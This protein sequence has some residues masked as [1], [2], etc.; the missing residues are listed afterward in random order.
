MPISCCVV[1]HPRTTPRCSPLPSLLSPTC[2]CDP[3]QSVSRLFALS[4]DTPCTGRWCREGAQRPNPPP[5]FGVA[6]TQQC[7]QSLS[8]LHLAPPLCPVP[9]C[10]TLLLSIMFHVRVVLFSWFFCF[11][12]STHTQEPGEQTTQDVL[13]EALAAAGRL[14]RRQKG[15]LSRL[16]CLSTLFAHKPLLACSLGRGYTHPL[17][18]VARGAQGVFTS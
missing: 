15:S 2:L 5:P 17:C 12:S 7:G 3:P 16:A 4:L 6:R 13:L 10:P 18:G 1:H 11:P 9:L 14:A 8:S